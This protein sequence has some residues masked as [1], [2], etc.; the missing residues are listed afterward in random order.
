[1]RILLRTHRY[2]GL[3]SAPWLVFFA[4]TGTCQLFDLHESE[5]SLNGYQAPQL[6]V[7]LSDVHRIQRLSGWPGTVFRAL[8]LLLS[9]SFLAT[10]GIGVIVAFKLE[11]RRWLIWLCLLT[12]ALLPA[13]FLFLARLAG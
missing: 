1:M 12:G 5:K 7:S 4:L 13:L 6:L 10:A 9:A 2:L 3:A 8:G 11:K